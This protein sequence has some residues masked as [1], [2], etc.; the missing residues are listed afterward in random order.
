[1]KVM[2]I[3]IIYF[4]ERQELLEMQKISVKYL[5]NLNMFAMKYYLNLSNIKFSFY[6]VNRYK[7]IIDYSRF[8]KLNEEEIDEKFI[9]GHGPGGSNVNKTTNC[10]QLKHIPTGK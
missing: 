7:T 3:I 6:C 9:K 1:M 10:V 5:L 4:S 8:P 2:D